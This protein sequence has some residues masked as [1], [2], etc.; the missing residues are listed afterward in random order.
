[1]LAQIDLLNIMARY[2]C[3]IA[4]FDNVIQWA[5]H[6]NNKKTLFVKNDVYQFQSRNV[7]LNHLRK[8]YDMQHMKPTQKVIVLSDVSN[9][10]VFVKVFDFKQQLLSLL[11]DKELMNPSNLVLPN[12]PNINNDIISNLLIGTLV[13]III[14]MIF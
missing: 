14:T 3:H 11:R 7:L 4:V 9:N 5:I 13:H 2:D 6:F 1:M 8:S 10:T 12:I